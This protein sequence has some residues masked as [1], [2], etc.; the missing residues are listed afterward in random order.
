VATEIL[1]VSDYWKGAGVDHRQVF[2]N[3][4]DVLAYLTTQVEPDLPKRLVKVR[5]AIKVVCRAVKKGRLKMIGKGKNTA[6]LPSGEMLV[7]QETLSARRDRVHIRYGDVRN[8]DTGTVKKN[9]DITKYW[10]TDDK[11][12]K[13]MSFTDV[14]SGFYH[15]R[16]VVQEVREKETSEAAREKLLLIENTCTAVVHNYF[17]FIGQ[18]FKTNERGPDASFGPLSTT[19]KIVGVL[20]GGQ[21]LAVSKEVPGSKFGFVVGRTRLRDLVRD[22]RK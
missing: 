7:L 4:A 12:R 2:V 1:D 8:L 6:I 13:A 3:L 18:K 10:R 11:L 9:Q 21:A 14:N 22:S 15:L 5:N 20:P 16:R 17:Q 19:G